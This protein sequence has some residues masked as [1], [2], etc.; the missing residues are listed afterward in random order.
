METDI[1]PYHYQNPDVERCCEE[2]AAEI[3]R[4]DY[5]LNRLTIGVRI[6]IGKH[7][8]EVKRMLKNGYYEWLAVHFPEWN[9]E[10]TRRW[11]TLAYRVGCDSTLADKLAAFQSSAAAENFV[12]LPAPIQEKVMEEQAF[13]WSKFEA[14]VLRE[15]LREHM[16]DERLSLDRRAGDVLHA[17]EEART[18][19]NPRVRQAAEEIYQEHRE[20]FAHLSDMEPA[21]V[22]VAT[23]APPPAVAIPD[24]PMARLNEIEDGLWLCRWDGEQF[25]PIAPVFRRVEVFPGPVVIAAFPRLGD[26]PVAESWQESI[27]RALPSG[28]ATMAM[29][30]EVF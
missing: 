5:G 19:D 6:E 25:V 18:N 14:L 28:I 11:R 2:H 21:E 8:L 1:V 26:G 23:N 9:E 15:N 30:S 3:A 29:Y 10:T 16:T 20:T 7:L 27:V 4:L 22:D 17:I 24:R 12:C 13:T